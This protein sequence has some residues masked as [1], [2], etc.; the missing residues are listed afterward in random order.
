MF[1]ETILQVEVELLDA[2]AGPQDQ[3]QSAPWSEPGQWWEPVLV[4]EHWAWKCAWCD[5]KQFRWVDTGYECFECGG[6]VV[7]CRE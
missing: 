7:E 3:P 1:F 2:E 4:F 5:L 6:P